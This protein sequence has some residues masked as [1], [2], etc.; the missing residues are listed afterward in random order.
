MFIISSAGNRRGIALLNVVFIFIF[1]AVL[2]VSGLKMYGSVV[3]REKIN[4]TKGG[5]ENQVR[6]IMAWAAKNG[7]LP[8]KDE[9][10]AVF[11]GTNPPLDAWGKPIY[12]IY[13][14]S[15]TATGTGGLCGRTT[16]SLSN[17]A[18]ALVS[19]GS[20]F[21]VLSTADAVVVTD[22]KGATAFVPDK[23]DMYRIVTLDELKSQTG[24]FG[25]TA[26]RL[27]IV[28]NELPWTCS[29]ST[30]NLATMVG[31]GGAPGA[32]YTWS[33]TSPWS[34][35]S[36]NSTTGL[37]SPNTAITT[38]AGTYPLITVNL[39]DSQG[40][41]AQ[42]NYNLKVFYCGDDS[43]IPVENKF[44][45]GAT[46]SFGGNTVS[47]ANATV[48]LNG[49]LQK[50]DING[51]AAIAVTNAYIGGNVTLGGS[52][53]LGNPATPG[54]IYIQGDLDLSGSS[55]IY[56][57][58]IYVTGNITL[59][60]S[61]FLGLNDNSTKINALGNIDLLSGDIH[62]E[63]YVG[64][65][66]SLKSVTLYKNAYITGDLALDYTPTLSG[67]TT[68][69]YKGSLSAPSYLDPGILAKC[70][71]DTSLPPAAIPVAMPATTIPPLKADSWYTSN[72][73]LAGGA[74]TNN[75]KIF[76]AG[77]YSANA[78][79]SNVVIVSKG[80]ITVGSGNDAISGVLF[81]PN[82]KITFGGNSFTGY[83]IAKNGFFVTSG[84]ST[85]TLKSLSTYI[86]GLPDYPFVYP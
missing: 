54:I 57:K 42:R 69:Y 78:S 25:R 76:A 51:G 5:L 56:A 29:G 65:N 16:T 46:L 63:L 41:T 23:S 39:V 43:G 28:N 2:I 79:A 68:L 75:I 82:G 77:N 50:D 31:D 22:S 86:P 20:D 44:I 18:F 7:R 55:G 14:V 84:G 74:L 27:R 52:Q 47:G 64:G 6:M 15:L 8:T 71:K 48:V 61:P 11:G 32:G 1:I 4:D 70:I 38:T 85:V 60:G 33:L 40:V 30:A 12:Y 80:N 19:G 53:T 24:C 9:Y 72:G 62:G 58:A 66:L 17:N 67:S 21:T 35:L 59:Q 26:G 10:P 81:A 3:V 49:N 13:D 45:Q 83:V 36:I 37:L 34:W 73:Y